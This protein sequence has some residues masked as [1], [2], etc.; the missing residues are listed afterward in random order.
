MYYWKVPQFWKKWGSRNCDLKVNGFYVKYLQ[1]LRVSC[2]Y[3]CF[4]RKYQHN[5]MKVCCTINSA[6]NKQKQAKFAI[7]IDICSCC[8]VP[9]RS[10][11]K[12]LFWSKKKLGF[13]QPFA[14][15][16]QIYVQFEIFHKQLLDDC[17]DIFL[18]WSKL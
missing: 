13:V 15:L 17:L 18:T 10:T 5:G 16:R 9:K 2:R 3:H 12:L 11:P 4:D 8:K 1:N 7:F 6:A 14:I